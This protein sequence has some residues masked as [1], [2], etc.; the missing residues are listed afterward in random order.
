MIN[1]IRYVD[2]EWPVAG[3]GFLLEAGSDTL[4]ATAKHILTYFKSD[5]MNAVSFGTMLKS[6]RMHPKNNPDDVVVVGE[7]INEGASEA[8][9]RI[10]SPRDWLLFKVKEKSLNI[11]P[12]KPRDTPLE[13]GEPV[14]IVGWR[15]SDRDCPQVIY[16]GAY[17][18]SEEGSILISTERLAENTMPGLSGSPVI[19]SMGRVIGL[20][21]QKAGRLER[22]SSLEYPLGI[23]RDSADSPER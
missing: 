8:I 2:H 16:K 12:L 1:E 11:Q 3:C 10:P 9:D 4:A 6:W 23:L 21:S 18:R 7:L 20:M 14:Y 5:S 15:Y 22:V 19:D 17:V 13:P